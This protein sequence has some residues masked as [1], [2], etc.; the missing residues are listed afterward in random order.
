MDFYIDAPVRFAN[1]LFALGF[2]GV[3]EKT[4]GIIHDALPCDLA[5]AQRR[6]EM[7]YRA[8]ERLFPIGG[9]ERSHFLLHTML[10]STPSEL[11]TTAYFANLDKVFAKSE[12]RAR[13]GHV[14]LGLGT[15][16]SGSSTLAAILGSVEGALSIHEVPPLIY[17]HP[18]REQVEF[19]MRRLEVLSWHFPLTVNSG[20]YYLWV[21]DEFFD[22]FPEGKAIGAYRAT[23][24]CASSWF[25]IVPRWS[26]R[27]VSSHNG[28]W[29]A[30]AWD[31]TLPKYPIPDGAHRDPDEVKRD[32]IRRYIV[33]YNDKL[34]S[35]ADR[36]PERFL[37]VRT[38]DLDEPSTRT[39]IS[40]FLGASVTMSSVR[41]NVQTIENWGDMWF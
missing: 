31:P 13:Q 29:G 4:L 12:P 17:W 23:E 35:Y 22:R 7:I 26:N 2:H 28:I 38:E 25:N 18:S 39:C 36:F 24:P 8:R 3:A 34:K 30:T 37:L 21:L 32:H 9:A 16:R 33:E 27:W 20:Y 11:L 1:F 5:V 14:V 19:H 15:G 6:G 10:Q 40:D 41:L